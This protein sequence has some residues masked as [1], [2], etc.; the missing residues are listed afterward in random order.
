VLLLILGGLAAFL[1]RKRVGHHQLAS[2]R[3]MRDRHS[4]MIDD[5]DAGAKT[6]E[7][8]LQPVDSIEATERTR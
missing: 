7:H 3:Q 5:Q 6:I 1:L 8:S 2:S 4:Q